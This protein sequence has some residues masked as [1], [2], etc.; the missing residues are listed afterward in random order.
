MSI[1]DEIIAQIEPELDRIAEE[2]ARDLRANVNVDTGALQGSIRVE[3]SG[4]LA[5]I[6]RTDATAK[7]GVKYAS[8]VNSGRGW[9]FP[10]KAPYLRYRDGS[11]HMSSAPYGGSHY[12]EKTV[13]QHQ[14]HDRVRVDVIVMK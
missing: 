5:R 3:K 7:N 11:R 10:K 4:R 6:V 9:V 2:V 1:A 13:S 14:G 12:A 8:I